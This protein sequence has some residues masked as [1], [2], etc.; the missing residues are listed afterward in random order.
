MILSSLSEHPAG[1][2]AKDLTALRT[3]SGVGLGD[4]RDRLIQLLNEPSFASEFA[5]YD[6][7]YYLGNPFRFELRSGPRAGEVDLVGWSAV[8]ALRESRVVEIM[9]HSWSTESSP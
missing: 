5:E 1:L 7:L 8:Y 4:S 6:I 3:E 2:V 9:L